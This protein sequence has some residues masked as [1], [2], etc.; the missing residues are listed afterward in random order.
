MSF[1]IESTR[2]ARFSD[3]PQW[4]FYVAAVGRTIRELARIGRGW[5][6][7]MAHR[8]KLGGGHILNLS[9]EVVL[10]GPAYPDRHLLASR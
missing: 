7:G 8:F 4:H 2:T 10:L 9:E 5:P 1:S 6:T 3:I